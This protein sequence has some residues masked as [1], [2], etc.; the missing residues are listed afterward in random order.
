MFIF[1]PTGQPLLR[2]LVKRE[3]SRRVRMENST[4]RMSFSIS[5][6]LGNIG[7]GSPSTESAREEPYSIKLAHQMFCSSIVAAEI[8]NQRQKTKRLEFGAIQCRP[9]GGT[10]IRMAVRIYTSLMTGVL[11]CC[12]ATIMRAVSRMSPLSLVS[13]TTD[14][15]WV[16]LGGITTM[17]GMMISTFLICT[18][19]R[20][21]VSP[22]KS[23]DLKKCL[24]NPPQATGFTT[25]SQKENM[26]KL[27]VFCR[28]Q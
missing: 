20:D 1:A 26:S 8:S 18:A 28:P 15:R 14:M 13:P 9:L 24:L 2:V 23:Q 25:T 4:G 17:M 7:G 16:P 21:D 22:N 5:I 10:I 6:W 19:L 11:M 27:P 3:V 12:F